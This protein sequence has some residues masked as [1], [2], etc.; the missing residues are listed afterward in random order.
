MSVFCKLMELYDF[1]IGIMTVWVLDN[2]F[3][4][5]IQLLNLCYLDHEGLSNHRKIAEV[6]NFEIQKLSCF[7][8]INL[9]S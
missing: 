1:S 3:G 4:F 7:G 9:Y 6:E 5:L 2:F 8:Y